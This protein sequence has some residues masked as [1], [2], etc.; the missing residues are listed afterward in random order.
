MKVFL[1]FI[2]F[3]FIHNY[4]CEQTDEKI[5]DG[6][7]ATPHA[8]PWMVSV[9][10]NFLNTLTSTCGGVIISDIFLLT[11]ASCFEGSGMYLTQYY[12]IKAGIHMLTNGNESTEQI[13]FISHYI[14]HP[15]YTYDDLLNDIA[16]VRVLPPFQFDTLSVAPISLSNLI[17]VENMNLTTIGWGVRNLSNPTVL[18][19]TL[20]QV[21]IQENVECTKNKIKDPPTQLCATGACKGDMGGPLMIY[22]DDKQQYELVGITSH[23]SEC[24][25]EGVYTRVA[26]FIDWI[27]DILANSP[28]TPMPI[29]T[30]PSQPPPAPTTLPPEILGPPIPFVCDTSRSCGCSSTPVVFHDEPP[31]PPVPEHNQGRIV[32]G[33]TAQP[34]S[35]PWVVSLR[36][37]IFGHGCGGSIINSEWILTAAH[38]SPSLSHIVHI[39]VHDEQSPSPQIRN[40]VKAIIHPNYIPSP[41][42]INDIALMKVSPPIN[43]TTS[44]THAGL[45]CLPA[46]N[47]NLDYPKEGTR[48]AVIGWGTLSSGG[49]R[50]TKL[51]QVRVKTLAHDDWRCINATYDDTR[52]FCAAVDGG[53]KDSCQG[54]SGGPIHQWLDDHW[55]QVGIVS[56]GKGC[57]LADHPGVYTRL[58]FYYDWIQSNINET[59]MSSTIMTTSSI[60]TSTTTESSIIT[61]TATESNQAVVIKT[62][63][64]FTLIIY[65]A[66]QCLFLL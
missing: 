43:L 10:F 40:V 5:F 13:S 63:L 20:Q 53:G 15:N 41:K 38:C 35:W 9:R 46:Q 49:P 64:F 26:P 30:I 23:R 42:F 32:G 37:P 36:D 3:V 62:N 33:E 60:I 16:L 12:T 39:G 45:T 7:E 59:P 61:T 11:A 31:F 29:P 8:F 22:S 19:S 27:S 66:F 28:S 17:S 34:H 25:T 1:I 50:P 51:R 54:D 4:V 21:T 44:D 55:E 6:S 2:L 14:P 56:Y 58:S 47:D 24:T 65:I 57:A 48:L 18:S 52:Q